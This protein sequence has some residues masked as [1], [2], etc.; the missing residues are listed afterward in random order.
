MNESEEDIYG[1]NK[2]KRVNNNRE[3]HNNYRNSA[4]INKKVP[5]IPLSNLSKN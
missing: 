5:K 4:A 3:N 1:P 2:K